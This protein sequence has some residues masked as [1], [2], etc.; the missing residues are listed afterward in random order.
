MPLSR[1]P[2]AISLECKRKERRLMR[3]RFARNAFEGI[4]MPLASPAAAG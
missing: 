2:D 3:S 4:K 1:F